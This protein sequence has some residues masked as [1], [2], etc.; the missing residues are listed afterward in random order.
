MDEI[1]D[2]MTGQ[3][4]S[5]SLSIADLS[6][7]QPVLACFSEDERWYRATVIS[8]DKEANVASVF[9]VD[10]GNRETLPAS[11]LRHIPAKFLLLPK[12]ELSCSL[13]GVQLVS[14]EEWSKESVDA[15]RELM[16][17]AEFVE[18]DVMEVLGNSCLEVALRSDACPDFA[19]HLINNGH[20]SER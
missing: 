11:K 6:A 16:T 5:V 1:E 7:E 20:A 8:T 9:Y 10:Y 13:H 12:L 2:C 4:Q 3:S 14:E 19:R 15:F 18:A 17:E